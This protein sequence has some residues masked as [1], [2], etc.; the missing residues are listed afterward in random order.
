MY[1]FY[2]HDGKGQLG[3][4]KNWNYFKLTSPRLGLGLV[5]GQLYLWT[6]GLLQRLQHKNNN[7]HSV[8]VPEHKRA[9][10]MGN[11]EIDVQKFNLLYSIV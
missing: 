8:T 1:F 4:E 6:D 11:G 5:Q 7:Q 10:L 3:R 2:F 9:S